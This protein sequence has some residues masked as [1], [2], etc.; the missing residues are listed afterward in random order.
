MGIS[1]KISVYV[2]IC[3]EVI[4][5]SKFGLLN[6]YYLVQVRV[7][8]WSKVI[9]DLYLQWFQ[10]LCLLSYHFVWFFVPNLSANFL[11]ITF[12]KKGVQFI[13][14]QFFLSFTFEKMSF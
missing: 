11:Q 7:I 3:C 2:Y 9:F 13:I 6:S 12:F 4:I 8:I 1:L 14:F 10:A 5:W